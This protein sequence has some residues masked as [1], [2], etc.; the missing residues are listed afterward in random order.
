MTPS[1][2]IRYPKRCFWRI[3][4]KIRSKYRLYLY[5]ITLQN[6]Q[7]PGHA[8]SKITC[9]FSG[10]FWTARY[11]IFRAEC[12]PRRDNHMS[13]IV[14]VGYVALAWRADEFWPFLFT[15]LVAIKTLS[16]DRD[17]TYDCTLV[18]LKT[19]YVSDASLLWRQ[20][21]SLCLPTLELRSRQCGFVINQTSQGTSLRYPTCF[22]P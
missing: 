7:K 16:H 12:S 20:W 11:A 15:C 3:L 14:K 4:R 22:E 8:K 10:N 2:A 9:L 1:W 18:P 19:N 6:K 21:S 17:Y 13:I 5:W